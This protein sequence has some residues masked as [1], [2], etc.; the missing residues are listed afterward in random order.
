RPAHHSGYL[1]RGAACPAPRLHLAGSERAALQRGSTRGR[2]GLPLVARR[3]LQPRLRHL[4]PARRSG[5]RD[6]V[7]PQRLELRWVGSAVSGQPSAISLQLSAVS[8]QLSAVSVQPSGFRGL[9]LA[10]REMPAFVQHSGSCPEAM[11]K[12]WPLLS[13]PNAL[14][15]TG[16]HLFHFFK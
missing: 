15:E 10:A 11:A 13:P 2:L 12:R 5:S 3:P 16:D 6:L 1:Q 14:D 4:A 9:P 8:R 7:L